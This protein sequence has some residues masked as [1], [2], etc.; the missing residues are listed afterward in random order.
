MECTRLQNGVSFGDATARSYNIVVPSR[1]FNTFLPC[2]CHIFAILVKYH[3]Y[4]GDINGQLS[5]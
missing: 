5:R 1:S 2:V 3:P 4:G